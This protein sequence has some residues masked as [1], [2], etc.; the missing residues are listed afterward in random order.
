MAVLN[1]CPTPWVKAASGSVNVIDSPFGRPAIPG[2]GGTYTGL[3]NNVNSTDDG[4]FVEIDFIV[5][6]LD[7]AAPN[8]ISC[9]LLQ[10]SACYIV[11]PT[12]GKSIR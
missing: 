8:L 4:Q 11:P 1:R 2:Y 9:H 12:H 6:F 7:T 5:N 10:Q 3:A